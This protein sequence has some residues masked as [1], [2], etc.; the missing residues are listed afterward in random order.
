MALTPR[1]LAAAAAVLPLALAAACSG[2]AG[3]ALLAAAPTAPGGIPAAPA[4]GPQHLSETGSTLLFPLLRTWAAAY[5]QQ[6]GN[7]SIATAAMPVVDV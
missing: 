2:S 6:H 5:H 7:V 3:P 1:V 4:P